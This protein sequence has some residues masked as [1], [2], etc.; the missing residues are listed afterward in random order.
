MALLFLAFAN[1][2]MQRL[3]GSGLVGTVG[4]A[5]A[6]VNLNHPQYSQGTCAASRQADLGRT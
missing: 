3:H 6:I 5:I 1:V 4:K 2:L